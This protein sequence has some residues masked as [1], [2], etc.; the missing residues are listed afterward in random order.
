MYEGGLH[1]SSANHS[2]GLRV[3]A[4]LFPVDEEWIEFATE[5][6]AAV[7]ELVEGRP[8]PL[9]ALCSHPTTL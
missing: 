7:G 8:D 1:G 6:Q 5:C 9:E 3:L 2:E 4:S